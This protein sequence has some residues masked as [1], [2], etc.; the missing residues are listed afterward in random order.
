VIQ[1]VL[2]N[3]GPAAFQGATLLA[4]SFGGFTTG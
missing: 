4:I 3:S 2:A 1:L